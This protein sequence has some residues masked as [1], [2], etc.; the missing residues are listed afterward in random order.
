MNKSEYKAAA[1]HLADH[2]T[3]APAWT[4]PEGV[5]IET[6]KTPMGLTTWRTVD[7]RP[8]RQ[9]LCPE[10][11]GFGAGTA[12]RWRYGCGECRDEHY[13]EVR[14]ERD[15]LIPWHGQESFEKRL[16]RERDR[17]ALGDEDIFYRLQRYRAEAASWKRCETHDS[18]FMSRYERTRRAAFGARAH[19]LSQLRMIESAIACDMA[20]RGAVAAWRQQVDA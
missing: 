2:P 17:R 3:P 11:E 16:A 8:V 19:P 20:C 1:S 6:I 18:S 14:G 7:T 15:D 13:I 10:C 9:Y 12:E 4:L 5:R